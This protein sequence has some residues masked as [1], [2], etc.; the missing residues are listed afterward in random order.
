MGYK[1]VYPEEV[2]NGHRAFI[3]RRR[4]LRPSEEYRTP[5]DEEWQEFLGHFERR[6]VA[7]GACGRSYATPCIHEHSCLRCPLLRPDP[8]SRHRLEEI[9]NNL[10]ARIDEARR[11]GW[12]GEVDGLQVSLAGAQQKLAQL[13]ELATHQGTVQLGF[14]H[15]AGRVT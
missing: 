4:A 6:K 1:A 10:L 11:E 2:I 13:D 15:I 9:R 7:L 3:A 8:A 12:L 14:P 5:T